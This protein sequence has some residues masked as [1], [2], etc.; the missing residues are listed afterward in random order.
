[1]ETNLRQRGHRALHL[2]PHLL[3]GIPAFLSAIVHCG[4]GVLLDNSK[5]VFN[6]HT[7][8]DTIE[9]IRPESLAVSLQLVIDM[10]EKIDRK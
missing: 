7:R 2:Q 3:P 9:H 10:L 6:Y 8:F 4:S 5:L 1:M